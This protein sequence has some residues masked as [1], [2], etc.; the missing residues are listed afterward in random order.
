MKTIINTV[1]APAPIGP[2]SQAVAA[3]GLFLYRAKYPW[4]LQPAKYYYNQ[5]YRRSQTGNGK[6]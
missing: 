4:T 2:Y 5:Y 3:A 1:N 6:P